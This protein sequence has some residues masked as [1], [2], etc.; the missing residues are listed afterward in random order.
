MGTQLAIDTIKP[1]DLPAPPQ[2]ALEILRACSRDDIDNN[3][4]ADFTQTDPVLTVEVLR[5]V[6]SPLF[7]IATEV[8]SVRHA[9]T[10]L[11]TR[12]LRNIVLC[13]T[14]R[15]AVQNYKTPGLDLTL[16][17]EDTL[18][19]AVTAK[20]LGKHLGLDA[21]ECFTVGL[22]QDFGFL[23]LFFLHQEVAD[24]FKVLRQCDPEQR[25]TKE[26]E[27]FD[28]SHDQVIKILGQHWSLP[29]SLID[30]ISHHHEEKNENRS[31]A[32]ILHG[33]DW[34]NAIF[35]VH[36]IADVLDRTRTELHDT[37][38]LSEEEMEDLLSE[39][40]RTVEDSARALGLRIKQ[41]IDYD[42]VIR[43]ANTRLARENTDYQ[44]LTWKLEKAIEERDKLSEELNREIVIAQEVQRS[45]MP[46]DMPDGF[47]V[48]GINVPARNISGDFFD[49]FKANDERIWFTL[50][51]VAGKGINAGLLMAKTASLY[52]CLAKKMGDPARLLEIIN[53]EICETSVRGFFVTMVAGIYNPAEKTVQIANAGHLPVI[54]VNKQGRYASLEATEQPLGILPGTKYNLSKPFSLKDTSLYLY[55]DGVTEAVTS[56][57]K[58][59]GEKGLVDLIVN[60]GQLEPEKR[61]AN[62]ISAI[63]PATK[64]HDDITLLLLEDS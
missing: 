10:L 30:A 32:S 39:V 53:D 38:N 19:R 31:L 5:V 26:I 50:G 48:C 28:T 41:Q 55:S 45:L 51:D 23:I 58:M 12:A 42:V 56:D 29:D 21:D 62:I 8:S 14:V 25:R 18:R 60:M 13:L 46:R 64:L 20:L 52:R 27:I 49:Y 43:Q 2:S 4:L 22:L 3:Q 16:F 35:C 6:N 24:K 57:G 61:L 17:W 33:A 1:S 63:R 37:F 59:L 36:D 9:I 34:V 11:G 47:P 40:P 54:M 7:G 44:E 15:E